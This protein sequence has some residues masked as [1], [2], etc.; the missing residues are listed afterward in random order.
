MDGK[1]SKKP[2]IITLHAK[3]F[4][5]PTFLYCTYQSLRPYPLSLKTKKIMQSII[6]QLKITL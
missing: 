3:S 5:K 4:F 2:K 6:N 1:G